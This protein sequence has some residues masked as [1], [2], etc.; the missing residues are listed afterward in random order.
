MIPKDQKRWGYVIVWE[1]RPWPGM[2]ERF[3]EAYG[4]QGIWATLFRESTGFISTELNRDLADPKRYLT[5][6]F[7][8]SQDA[9]ELFRESK[10]SCYAAIDVQCEVLTEHERE[11]GRFA[12][13]K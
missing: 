9:Y 3:E 13:L 10:A 5:M 11:V 6:D 8:E 12:R 2:E 1:F 7:W 4:P